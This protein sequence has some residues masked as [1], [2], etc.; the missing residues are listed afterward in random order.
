M[1]DATTSLEDHCGRPKGMDLGPGGATDSACVQPSAYEQ[2][3]RID[4]SATC[5]STLERVQSLGKPPSSYC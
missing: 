1:V 5:E 4:Y 3:R 2:H